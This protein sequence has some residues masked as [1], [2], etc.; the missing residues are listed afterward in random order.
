M[1]SS[2]RTL[3]HQRNVVVVVTGFGQLDIVNETMNLE[4]HNTNILEH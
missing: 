2:I 3:S 1:H 4:F